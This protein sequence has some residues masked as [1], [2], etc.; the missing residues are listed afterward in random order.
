MRRR[1]A[2]PRA[3]AVVEKV[4]RQLLEQKLGDFTGID[5]HCIG[6]EESYGPHAR[7]GCGGDARSGAS[8]SSRS[9][10]IRRR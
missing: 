8:R 9:T 3:A 7:G 10:R 1:R 2:A 6:A 4:R 5:I